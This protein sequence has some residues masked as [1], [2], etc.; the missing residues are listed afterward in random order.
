MP[1]SGPGQ[2]PNT[3]LIIIYVFDVVVV[4]QRG[5][6]SGMRTDTNEII[7]SPEVV[8]ECSTTIGSFKS[9]IIIII[10]V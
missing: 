4:L 3:I 10:T 7:G 9:I 2:A 5:Y 8:F 6:F 1:P